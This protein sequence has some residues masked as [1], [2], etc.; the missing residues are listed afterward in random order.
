[1][2]GGHKIQYKDDVLESC[3]PETYVF[4]L[5]N[6]TTINSIKIFYCFSV[7]VVLPF[8]LLLIPTSPPY[9]H[10]QLSPL[11]LFMS[12]LY[13]F[14]CLP[15]PLLSPSIPLPCPLWSLSVCSLSVWSVGPLYVLLGKVCVC[16]FCPFLIGLLVFL[17]RSH[18]SS[19]YIL[20]IK[21]LSEV[22][23]ANMFSQIVGSVF[24][25]M[26]LN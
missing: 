20:E 13:L 17:V 8:S 15:L 21:P 19:L 23:L 26:L 22:L 5:T 9:S 24:I 18:V 11:Y 10:S 3:S 12:P 14:L 1:M 2:G 25:L 4:L 6:V 16:V 7:T